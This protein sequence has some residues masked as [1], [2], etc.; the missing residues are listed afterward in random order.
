MTIYMMHRAPL[1]YDEDSV[2]RPFKNPDKAVE[3]LLDEYFLHMSEN[4]YEDIEDDKAFYA[5]LEKYQASLRHETAEMFQE[6]KRNTIEQGY[7]RFE[8]P[9][10]GGV[11]EAHFNG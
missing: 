2:D 11:Y 8:I 4:W 1:E 6:Y 3:T 9:N 10:F 5:A 7:V